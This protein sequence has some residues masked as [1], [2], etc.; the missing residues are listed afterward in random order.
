MTGAYHN[1]FLCIFSD[2]VL[3][4]PKRL[5]SKFEDAQQKYT[6][7]VT[8]FKVKNWISSASLGLCA[9]RT[10]DNADRMGKPLVVAFY[11]VDYVKNVK[12]TNYWR[13][14]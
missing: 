6:D 11:D 10:P 3:F 14:R 1:L 5:Q 4:Q 12:G 13:N 7:D 2:I 9:H 8:V